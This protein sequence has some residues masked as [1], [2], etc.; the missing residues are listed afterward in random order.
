MRMKNGGRNLGKETRETNDNEKDSGDE[1]L[2]EFEDLLSLEK[3]S[4][5][6]SPLRKERS[7]TGRNVSRHERGQEMSG[8]A[9]FRDT[10]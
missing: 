9:T 8:I 4:S 1:T 7:S 3:I 5:V 2:F 6:Q 10:A